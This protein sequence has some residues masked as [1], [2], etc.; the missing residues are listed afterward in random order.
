MVIIIINGGE[1]K[2]SHA[3]AF[4]DSSSAKTTIILVGNV[5]CVNILDIPVAR[6]PFPI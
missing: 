4:L 3:G 2:L 5:N 6:F 1:S